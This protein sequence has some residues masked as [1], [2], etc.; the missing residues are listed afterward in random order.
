[1]SLLLADGVEARGMIGSDL[2]LEA[3]NDALAIFPADE[4]VILAPA[5]ELTTW[6]EFDLLRSAP[7]RRSGVR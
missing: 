6:S 2:P 7:A 4:I 5:S 3:I 1:M